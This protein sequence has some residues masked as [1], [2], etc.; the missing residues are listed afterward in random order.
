MFPCFGVGP[1][2]ER[3]GARPP[4][5]VRWARDERVWVCELGLWRAGGGPAASGCACVSRVSV[6]VSVCVGRREPAR[7]ASGGAGSRPCVCVGRG[8][9]VGET[10]ERRGPPASRP[11]LGASQ[12]RTARRGPTSWTREA[13]RPPRRRAAGGSGRGSRGRGRGRKRAGLQ[14]GLTVFAPARP[15]ARWL[16]RPL[17][18]SLARPPAGL[19]RRSRDSVL[20]RALGA[21]P[22][23]AR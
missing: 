1:G 9:R 10:P 16:A 11:G 6:C 14:R 21:A 3:G 4:G 22:G 19:P 20:A 2:V 5:E 23:L 8:P 12:V 15:L 13:A 7:V 18:R 17:A